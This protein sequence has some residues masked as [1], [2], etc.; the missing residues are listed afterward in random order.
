MLKDLFQPSPVKSFGDRPVPVQFQAGVSCILGWSSCEMIGRMS[1]GQGP[2][3]DQMGYGGGIQTCG[4]TI[5]APRQNSW[6]NCCN[7]SN[8]YF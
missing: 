8:V 1:S 4:G 2:P 6:C 3:P 5:K 7:Q